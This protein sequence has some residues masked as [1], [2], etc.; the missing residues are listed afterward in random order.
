MGTNTS[1]TLQEKS[2][3]FLSV[4]FLTVHFWTCPDFYSLQNTRSFLQR[5]ERME[6]PDQLVWIHSKQHVVKVRKKHSNYPGYL[7][8][9]SGISSCLWKY[10]MMK[11]AG[12]CLSLKNNLNKCN[13]K[14]WGIRKREFFWWSFLFFFL[15]GIITAFIRIKLFI[16]SSFRGGLLFR[17]SGFWSQ[18]GINLAQ[19]QVSQWFWTVT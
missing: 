7:Q 11:I 1:D 10:P 15:K 8:L 17:V 13:Q 19:D 16:L 12:W 2:I 6:K 5:I 3:M 14:N 18:V 4:F 9:S